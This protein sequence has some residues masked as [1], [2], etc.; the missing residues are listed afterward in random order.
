[1]SFKIKLIVLI[2][3]WLIVVIIGIII[4]FLFVIV[5]LGDFEIIYTFVKKNLGFAIQIMDLFL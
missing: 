2:F 5:F 3:G 4:L 1:M